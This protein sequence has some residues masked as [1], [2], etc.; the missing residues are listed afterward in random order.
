[1][2]E[3]IPASGAESTSSIRGTQVLGDVVAMV[4]DHV[5]SLLTHQRCPPFRLRSASA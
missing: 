1:V 4:V 3:W 2:V 5:D